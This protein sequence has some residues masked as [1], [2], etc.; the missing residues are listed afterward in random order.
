MRP[1]A[2]SAAERL[3]LIAVA[4]LIAD[5][6]AKR[7]A[8][9]LQRIGEDAQDG[10]GLPFADGAAIRDTAALWLRVSEWLERTPR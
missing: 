9:I 3:L 10:G 1:P 5:R 8:A 4:A 2:L 7:R 6:P